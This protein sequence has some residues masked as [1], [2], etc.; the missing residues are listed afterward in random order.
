MSAEIQFIVSLEMA[1]ES[2]DDVEQGLSKF[3]STARGILIAEFVE[4]EGLTLG[5]DGADAVT[6]SL[7]SRRGE[8]KV[9]MIR[10]ERRRR[11]E[12]RSSSLEIIE[13]FRFTMWVGSSRIKLFKVIYNLKESIDASQS[14]SSHHVMYQIEH[15]G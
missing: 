8:V 15:E 12:T 10:P 3:S 1:C 14:R 6:A 5:F 4:V 2:C 11:L 9:S 7:V 13:P